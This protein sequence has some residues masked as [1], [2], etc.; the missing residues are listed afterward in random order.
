MEMTSIVMKF[1]P[2]GVFCLMARTFGSM[3]FEGILPLGKYVLCVLIG[4]AARGFPS[5]HH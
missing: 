1:A 3:G 5:I 2:I 4:L